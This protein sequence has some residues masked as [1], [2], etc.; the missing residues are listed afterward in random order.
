MLLVFTAL[1]SLGPHPFIDAAL[2]DLPAAVHGS[3]TL[4]KV[5]LIAALA[6]HILTTNLK[7]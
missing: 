4:S 2:Q 6:L 5:G 1:S 7:H 3:K